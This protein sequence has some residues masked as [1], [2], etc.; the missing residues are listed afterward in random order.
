MAR[1]DASLEVF[2][3]VAAEPLRLAEPEAAGTA[4]REPDAEPE[5][6][7]DPDAEE[8]GAAPVGVGKEAYNA[9]LCCGT[10]LEEAGTRAV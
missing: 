5:A 2:E 10:Q 3:G 9:E 1:V 4:G 7:A 6:A 8:A